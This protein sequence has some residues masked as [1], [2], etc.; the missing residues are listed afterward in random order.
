MN[1]SDSNPINEKDNN[2]SSNNKSNPINNSD[3]N[4]FEKKNK[5]NINSNSKQG[6]TKNEWDS[7]VLQKESLGGDIFF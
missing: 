2:Y 7:C 1:K 6:N 3:G 5:I 4:S